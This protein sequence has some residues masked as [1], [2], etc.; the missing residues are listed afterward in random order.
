M[1]GSGGGAHVAAE[2]RTKRA[3]RLGRWLRGAAIVVVV[4]AV[5]L[6]VVLRVGEIDTRVL[7]GGLFYQGS[8]TWLYRVA[9]DPVVRYELRPGAEG[10]HKGGEPVERDYHVSVNA[11]GARGKAWPLENA[12]DVFRVVCVGGSTMYGWG[13][14]DDET[15]CAAL[16]R[17]L[18]EW[19]DAARAAPG[20]DAIAVRRVEAW[21]FAA[22]AHMTS[23]AA[24]IAQHKLG[25]LNPDLVLVQVFNT[26]RRAVLSTDE[27]KPDISGER[28]RELAASDD[29]FWA[30]SFPPPMR[31]LRDA[32]EILLRWSATYR[33]LV[34]LV[35]KH[36]QPADWYSDRFSALQSGALNK[37]ADEHGTKVL[38]M[39]IPA[40]TGRGLPAGFPPSV[41]AG[42]VVDLYEPGREAT[43]Y[44]VH[45]PAA[46]LAEYADRVA[47]EL[48]R[49]GWLPFP[50]GPEPPPPAHARHDPANTR[51]AESGPRTLP[52]ESAEDVQAVADAVSDS[53]TLESAQID[54]TR[55]DA[56]FCEVARPTEC[57]ELRLSDPEFL[58]GGRVLGP[59]CVVFTRPAGA[60]ESVPALAPLLTALEKAPSP[61]AVRHAIMDPL[62]PEPAGRTLL[63]SFVGILAVACLALVLLAWGFA[64]LLLRR[65]ERATRRP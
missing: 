37:Q 48:G 45:P 31:A 4:S 36:A 21:N 51:P 27:T 3:G 54:R 62:W 10:P 59:W 23:Q 46:Y 20:G 44:E 17:R 28:L 11:H 18:Q 35:R 29:W 47:V 25:E 12:T 6:E 5:L 9:E 2:K 41:L 33:T 39:L 53:L 7:A 16:E 24:R 38:Y 56:R 42:R 1:W 32:H 61:W 30:E 26:G 60:A 64:R 55:V 13:V 34:G 65:R 63:V 57:Y 43:F 58:C 50:A 8:P 15:A 40:G 14:E 52:P 19:L 22:A 49:R